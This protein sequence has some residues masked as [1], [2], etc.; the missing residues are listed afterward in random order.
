MS[1]FQMHVSC[2]FL[3]VLT[4]FPYFLLSLYHC[5]SMLQT[6]GLTWTSQNFQ[7]IQYT[8][9]PWNDQTNSICY[10]PSTLPNIQQKFLPQLCAPL[11]LVYLTSTILLNHLFKTDNAEIFLI[12]TSSY[13]QGLSILFL[14]LK[15]ILLKTE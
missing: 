11:I 8:L 14:K 10:F 1:S 15:A 5:L 6:L 13:I 2:K 9:L 12:H 3:T 7:Q 4:A